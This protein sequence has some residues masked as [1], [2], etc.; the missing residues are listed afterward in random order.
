MEVTLQDKTI[1]TIQKLH[2]WI[3]L[4]LIFVQLLWSGVF[5]AGQL[6][7][8]SQPPILTAFIR[9]LISS[10]CLIAVLCYVSPA[11]KFSLPPRSTYFVL[12]LMGLFGVLIYNSLVYMGLNKTTAAS[13][14]LLIPT[15]QPCITAFLSN[16]LGKES[17]SFKQKIGFILGL[18]GAGAILTDGWALKISIENIYGNL[19]LVG[20]ALSF[21]IYSV[22]GKSVLEI[23]TPLQ[24][25][26]YTTA[27]GTIFLFIL[28]FCCEGFGSLLHSNMTFWLSMIYLAILISTLSMLWWNDGIKVIGAGKT[29]ALTYLM[30]PSALL[31]ALLILNQKPSLLQIIG[32]LIGLLGVF[33]ASGLM[34][35]LKDSKKI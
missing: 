20:A 21:S 15:I 17:V 26:T 12:I 5:I 6:A 25:S 19:L 31:L 24:T 9:N 13:A 4:K 27:I 29:G 34:T 33:F 30:L 10:F 28:T 2:T 8:A 1:F 22:L 11:K 32:G 3:Y 14:S 23:L 7:V 16:W 18:T 35:K